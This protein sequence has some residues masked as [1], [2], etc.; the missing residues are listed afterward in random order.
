M[1]AG[2]FETATIAELEDP[3]GQSLIRRRFDI[4]SFGISARSAHKAGTTVI[5]EH[6]ERPSGH[7]ELYLVMS[8]RA[9]FVVDGNELD[10]T[11]G[12]L[13][14]VR[15]PA[16]TRQAVAIEDETIVIATGGRP[17]EAFV[18]RSWE[19][20]H[21]VVAMLDGGDFEGAKRLLVESLGR[22]RDKAVLLYNLA[23]AEAQLGEA[24]EAL[25]H[26]RDALRMEP[27]LRADARDD[28]DLTKLRGDPRFVGL[29]E[30]EEDESS[31]RGEAGGTGGG[32]VV[33]EGGLEPP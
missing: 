6:D 20:D 13:V 15:D 10:A 26:L 31:R 4:R 11:A 30:A 29:I 28:N 7:E 1:T 12:T 25:Q 14:F 27:S 3:Q 19:T 8:G 22:Y 23:C 21:E 16:V 24:E 9:R 18:P 2:S 17:G 5:T 33:S 32:R